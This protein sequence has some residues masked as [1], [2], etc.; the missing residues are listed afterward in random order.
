MYFISSLLKKSTLFPDLDRLGPCFYTIPRP[1][2]GPSKFHNFSRLPKLCGN[3]AKSQKHLSIKGRRGWGNTCV[4]EN[5]IFSHHKHA[6]HAWTR[7]HS[8]I[9]ASL[10]LFSERLSLFIGMCVKCGECALTRTAMLI[11]HIRML[12]FGLSVTLTDE[13]LIQCS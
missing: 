4:T 8:Y 9:S 5:D 3:P 12:E 6:K 7:E 1:E 11:T 13:A 10:H 2:E